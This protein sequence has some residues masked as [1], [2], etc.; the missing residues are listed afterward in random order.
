VATTLPRALRLNG[1]IPGILLMP[2]SVAGTVIGVAVADLALAQVASGFR[3]M[4]CSVLGL[5][6][7]QTH[8]ERRHWEPLAAGHVSIDSMSCQKLCCD[9]QAAGLSVSRLAI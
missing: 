4:P 1:Q 3:L 2:D 7:L 9:A 6:W 5:L 8:F